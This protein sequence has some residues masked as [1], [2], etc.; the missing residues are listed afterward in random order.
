MILKRKLEEKAGGDCPSAPCSEIFSAA[1]PPNDGEQVVC[2]RADGWWGKGAWY[3]R[4]DGWMVDGM[5]Q[6][7]AFWMRVFIPNSQDH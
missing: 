6:D 4:F 2:I 7:I 5:R 1:T 3:A